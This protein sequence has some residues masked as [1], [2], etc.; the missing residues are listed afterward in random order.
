MRLGI[1]LGGTKT[2]AVIL[3]D[4]GSIIWRTRRPTPRQQ[5]RAIIETIAEVTETARSETGFDGPVGMGIPGSI[6]P[7]NGTIQGASTQVLN[8]Q[9]LKADCEA[10]TGRPF[11]IEND[12]NCFALSEASDGAGQDYDTVF[13]VILGTGCGG[14]F[15]N[16]GKV[17][18]GANNIA[19]EWGH[20]PLPWPVEGEYEGHDCWCGQRGCIETYL[21][22]P[23]VSA[24]YEQHSG[25]HLRVE[26]IAA[27]CHVDLVAESV[28][29]AFED[30]LGRA[31]S[32]IITI[33]DPDAIVLGGGLSNLERIYRNVPR[34]FSS[35][36]FSSS[37]V[38]TPILKPRFGDASGVRGAAWL[39][40]NGAG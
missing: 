17:L 21:A 10:E 4:D 23:S 9:N 25:T 36:V 28:L 2:E 37:P 15:V 33:F 38:I 6:N 20:T 3:G 29:Q 18:R 22:G 11:R 35:F 24:E 12:A 30:R 40:E 13:G 19:G 14:G 16:Q 39:W 7:S 31:L 32:Q 5:Y 1:D 34:K 26:D 8:G 27:R